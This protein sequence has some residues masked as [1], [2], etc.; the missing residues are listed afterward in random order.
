VHVILPGTLKEPCRSIFEKGVD[1]YI[2][3]KAFCSY[4]SPFACL[5]KLLIST[6]T[7]G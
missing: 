7:D 6:D 3:F 4:L 1:S 5:E 2:T